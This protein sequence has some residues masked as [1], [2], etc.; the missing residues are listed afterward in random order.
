[1]RAILI[2]LAMFFAAL[3]AMPA[4]AQDAG[5]LQW[6]MGKWCSNTAKQGKLCLTYKAREDGTILSTWA[7]EDDGAEQPEHSEAVM[8]IVDGR[9][10]LHSEDQGSDFREVSRGPNELV[11]ETTQSDLPKGSVERVTHRREGDVLVIDLI[12]AGGET[13]TSRYLRED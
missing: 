4:A 1:M 11:L 13:W 6:L 12:L 10:V 8:Q 7:T 9:V 3:T 5:E 2:G